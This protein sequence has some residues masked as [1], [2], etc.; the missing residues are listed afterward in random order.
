MVVDG[1]AATRRLTDCPYEMQSSQESLHTQPTFV[2]AQS[3]PVVQM[4]SGQE[5]DCAT[6]VNASACDYGTI[7][8]QEGIDNQSMSSR[9]PVSVHSSANSVA[10]QN[11]ACNKGSGC[12]VGI[13]END[14]SG[15]S[16]LEDRTSQ[17]VNGSQ[18]L[19][20]S[21]SDSTV[22]C[23]FLG[24]PNYILPTG[25]LD[26]DYSQN[27]VG[28]HLGGAPFD[29]TENIFL[30]PRPA[31]EQ[32]FKL[33]IPIQS[34]YATKQHNS[35][36]SLA[37]YVTSSSVDDVFTDELKED[38]NTDSQQ[39]YTSITLADYLENLNNRTPCKETTPGEPQPIKPLP[40]LV[41][42]RRITGLSKQMP[43]THSP[44]PNNSLD[45]LALTLKHSTSSESTGDSDPNLPKNNL[46]SVEYLIKR[47]AFLQT[48]LVE[49]YMELI[50]LMNEEMVSD[51]SWQNC[52][53]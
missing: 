19:L 1:N 26:K 18:V 39:T 52:C 44:N 5:T 32:A 8:N 46:C 38:S 49:R 17:A 13:P 31:P 27:L 40:Q 14:A 23:S 11:D 50:N 53:H 35:V 12:I 24:E 15:L 20:H 43:K 30:S 42:L 10:R 36:G 4:W 25:K 21:C 33:P 34:P 7:N 37:S 29:I 41:S 51:I 6:K 3:E 2:R 45:E 48:R 9:S 28:L 47:R 22:S 16:W